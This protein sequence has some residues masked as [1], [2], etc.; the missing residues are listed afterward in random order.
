MLNRSQ[1][2]IIHVYTGR[3][4]TIGKHSGT[5]RS[6][7][8]SAASCLL[9]WVATCNSCPCAGCA[10]M[11]RRARPCASIRVHAVQCAPMRLSVGPVLIISDYNQ[12]KNQPVIRLTQLI[13]ET[14]V[15]TLLGKS[16][17]MTFQDQP[18]QISMTYWH[19]IF[20]EINETLHMNTYQ[21]W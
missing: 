7:C 1:M 11:C 8:D 16:I 4:I 15:T 13:T 3:P 19:Y 6:P 21:N 5:A 17:S 12:C 2:L 10:S 9:H 20:P 14:R 18:K